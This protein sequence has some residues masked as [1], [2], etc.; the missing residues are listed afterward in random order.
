MPATGA[1][2]CDRHFCCYVS[3]ESAS[4]RLCWCHR[5]LFLVAVFVIF[6]LQLRQV[7]LRFLFRLKTH[8]RTLGAEF[9]HITVGFL[10]EHGGIPFFWVDEVIVA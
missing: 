9:Y 2:I 3:T 5:K 10:V 1:N 8:F 4:S 6:F 7:F